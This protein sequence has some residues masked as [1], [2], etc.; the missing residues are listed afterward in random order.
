[1]ICV[2]LTASLFLFQERQ[3]R[4]S[5]AAAVSALKV[6]VDAITVKYK[7]GATEMEDAVI[8]S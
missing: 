6:C 4:Q 8:Y 2:Y 5:R 7:T 3:E 1:M